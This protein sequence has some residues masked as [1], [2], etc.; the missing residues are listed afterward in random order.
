LSTW[1]AGG[2]LGS[3]IAPRGH[4]LGH[5]GAPRQGRTMTAVN[6]SGIRAEHS[7]RFSHPVAFHVFLRFPL[8]Y[9]PCST[10]SLW[11]ALP[12]YLSPSASTLVQQPCSA[13]LQCWANT[14]LER[15]RSPL[16]AA[17]APYFGA[18]G[19]SIWR[20]RPLTQE[21]LLRLSGIDWPGQGDGC[22]RRTLAFKSALEFWRKSLEVE[23]SGLIECKPVILRLRTLQQ[24]AIQCRT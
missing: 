9:R 6:V 11:H 4:S 10:L 22:P 19:W 1:L 5:S 2:G 15:D 21:L 23:L 12:G 3:V 16:T 18:G 20:A 24:F 13:C 14:D 8:Q 17:G 7:V